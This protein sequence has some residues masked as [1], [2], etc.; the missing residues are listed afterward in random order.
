MSARTFACLCAAVAFCAAAAAVPASPQDKAQEPWEGK[1]VHDVRPV[2][3]RRWRAVEI[4][5]L[6]QLRKG[7]PYDS[8]QRN[9][10][11]KTLF[12]QGKFSDVRIEPEITPAG[13]INFVV[14]V[15]EFQKII[16]VRFTGLKAIPP[17]TLTDL[18][19]VPEAMLNP[20]LLKLDQDKIRELLVMK[21]YH[22]CQVNYEII[23]EEDGAILHWHVTE[24]PLVTVRSIKFTGNARFPSSDL[25]ALMQTKEAGS[26]LFF[27]LA[28]SPYVQ[29]NLE[30]D[31]KR[32]K[33]AYYREGWLDI[34]KDDRI[35]I[36]DLVFSPSR[37]EVDIRIHID[38]GQKYRIR[39][40][41]FRG[42]AALTEEQM[43]QALTSKVEDEFTVTNAAKDADRIRDL[44]GERS[45]I[46]AQVE[47]VMTVDYV[48]QELDLLFRIVE[49][50]EITV[51]RISVNGN[52]RTR[53]DVILR[54][55]KDF[56][57]G[58]KF[59]LKLL[60]RGIQRLREHQYFDPM[61]GLSVHLEEGQE[62]NVRDVVIDVKEGS[63]GSIRFA[64]GY[65]SAFGILG[66]LE[67]E[68]RNFDIADL[69]K[70][71]GDLLGG[72]AFV[73][74]G[75][76]FRVQ[77]APARTSKSFMVLF[78]EPYVFGYDFGM[79]V[80]GRSTDTRLES[81]QERRQSAS[82]SFDHR[83]DPYRAELAVNAMRLDIDNV[84]DDAPITVK[85]GEGI[86]RIFSITTAL[87]YDTRDSIMIPTTGHKIVLS[88]EYAGQPLPGDFDFGKIIFDLESY[89]PVIEM[90]PDRHHVLNLD[91]TLKYARPRGDSTVPFFERFY[92]GGRDSIR[93]FHY[94]GVGPREAGD[95]IGGNAFA[96]FSAE[97][98]YPLVGNILWVS[99]FYDLCN[100]TPEWNDMLDIKWR[101]SVGFGIKFVIPQLGN[102]PVSIYFGFPLTKGPED[103][104]ETVTFDI[105]R[106]FF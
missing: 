101:N 55:L 28:G 24:G 43:R 97:Y 8:T 39:T 5:A 49:N 62:P 16:D 74:G 13:D 34:T 29:Y 61:A 25:K 70:S 14:K 68:Q 58:E 32:L 91:L 85:Q 1:I 79:G 80:V 65:S 103:E 86:N 42:N 83:F 47:Y 41:S 7:K 45:Y 6:V 38:E 100:L 99:G 93:G 56:A 98:A 78:K 64:G 60:Q 54:E 48:R 90:A 57:P 15:I 52:N 88:Y 53:F 72:D 75:Q 95:P 18:R 19:Q 77:F 27:P 73:G 63:T 46:L 104:R 59:N 36:E 30:E 33:L 31:L 82:L 76:I 105:G 44:Y 37:T 21:G 23:S 35:F 10:D 87:I 17:T 3:F 92:A 84:D 4:L 2:G 9:Q 94:R 11:L 66:I 102:I 20:Y 71:F 81:W 40:I 96:F 51:G 26:F 89:F 69:P 67:F 12:A 22:F 106:L 50:Q